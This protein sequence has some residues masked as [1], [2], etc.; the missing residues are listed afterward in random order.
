[1]HLLA[2]VRCCDDYDINDVHRYRRRLF[3]LFCKHQCFKE[4]T[5]QSKLCLWQKLG[6]WMLEA[7]SGLQD[8]SNQPFETPNI[9]E[10]KVSFLGVG[11]GVSGLRGLKVFFGV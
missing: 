5:P 3:S 8:C 10:F 9:S 1:M 2:T 7:A 6:S 4:L 11:F